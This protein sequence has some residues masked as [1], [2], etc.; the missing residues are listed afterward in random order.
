MLLGQPA[1]LQPW[2]SC[3]DERVMHVNIAT[4]TKNIVTEI[5]QNFANVRPTVP[6][7]VT[8]I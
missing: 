3:P 6:Q 1:S 2:K 8:R 5:T 7:Y 4:P